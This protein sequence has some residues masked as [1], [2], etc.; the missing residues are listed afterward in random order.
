MLRFCALAHSFKCRFKSSRGHADICHF[1]WTTLLQK[2][3]EA[4]RWLPGFE[5]FLKLLVKGK[6]TNHSSSIMFPKL[7][8][9]RS[10]LHSWFSRV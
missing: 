2:K 9:S 10:F 6:Y 1:F 8:I 5:A 7:C 3:K 4:N